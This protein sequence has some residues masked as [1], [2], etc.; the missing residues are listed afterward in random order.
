MAVATAATILVVMMFVVA[1]VI[2]AAAFAVVAVAA[3]AAS[4]VFH[5]VADLFLCG[6]AVFEYGT[7]KIERLASQ[8][9]VQVNLYLLFTHFYDTSVEAVA[10]FVL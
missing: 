6:I 7:L 3:T 1:V 4:E 2:A 9:V 10:V 8:R 5:E